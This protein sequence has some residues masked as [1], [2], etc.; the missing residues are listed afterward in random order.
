MDFIKIQNHHYH[1]NWNTGPEERDT[2]HRIQF[3]VAGLEIGYITYT[4]GSNRTIPIKFQIDNIPRIRVRVM[5]EQGASAQEI[6]L[7]L[8]NEF[9]LDKD[10]TADLLAEENFSRLETGEAIIV[11]YELDAT[12]GAVFLKN[13]GYSAQRDLRRPDAGVRHPG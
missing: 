12:G 1:V 8:K 2:P 3:S 6:A 4:T 13:R 11:V 7:V 9:H 10:D 5:H